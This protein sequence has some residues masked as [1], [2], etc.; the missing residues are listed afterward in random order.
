MKSHGVKIKHGQPYH[1][2][3]QG[4]VVNLNKVVKSHLNKLLQKMTKEDGANILP[5]LFTGICS[6]INNNWHHTIDDI[7]FRVY[8]NRDPVCMKHHII[9]DDVT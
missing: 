2:Q 7:P 3:S 1:P 5:L 6:I 4:Q 8:N 9:P